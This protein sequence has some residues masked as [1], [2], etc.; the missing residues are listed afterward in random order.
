MDNDSIVEREHQDYV[1]YSDQ[2]RFGTTPQEFFISNYSW[3]TDESKVEPPYSANNRDRDTWLQRFAKKDPI[4][5]GVLS[6]VVDIDKNRG[7]RMVGGRNQVGRF[8][9]MF[10]NW[11]AA[12]GVFGWR[13]GISHASKSFWN[14]DM[15]A[16]VEWGRS[17]RLGPLRAM[18]S[19]DPTK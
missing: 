10:H 3:F 2:P 17:S 5:I 4:L 8:T 12:P 9:R 19:V 15:G 13:Q 14:T 11:Q 1:G 18:Y 6:S 7:W 16:V